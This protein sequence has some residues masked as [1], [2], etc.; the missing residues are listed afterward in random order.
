MCVSGKRSTY[1]SKREKFLIAALFITVL[2]TSLFKL[3]GL[4]T[5]ETMRNLY[6]NQARI[7][8]EIEQLDDVLENEQQLRT[9]YVNATPDLQHYQQLLPTTAQQPVSI[10][11]LEKLIRSCPGRL[12]TMRVNESID[13][14]DYSAQNIS[15]K[16]TDLNSFPADLIF[17]LENFSQLLIIEQLEWQ[18]GETEADTISL[19]LSLYYLN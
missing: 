18:A 14:G 8:A 16:I 12:L 1:L 7:R 15:I 4:S 5:F 9:R 19:S 10:G 3:G 13:Y 11:A 17:Q 6:L 2:I